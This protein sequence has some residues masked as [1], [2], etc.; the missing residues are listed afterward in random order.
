[1]WVWNLIGCIGSQT[2]PDLL[3]ALGSH[4][5]SPSLSLLFH[6]MGVLVPVLHTQDIPLDPEPLNIPLHFPGNLSA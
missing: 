2:H 5:T 1:M 4:L 6:K 3:G